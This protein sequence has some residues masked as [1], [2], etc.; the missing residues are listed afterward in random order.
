MLEECQR[1]YGDAFTLRLA[2]LPPIVILSD[3]AAARQVFTG[4]PDK[5][6]SGQANRF[7]E[8]ALG[9]HSLL[10]LDGREHLRERKLMLPPFHGER[11]RAY[12]A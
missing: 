9:R 6:R 3:P 2:G 12:A 11:M 5:L 10:V 8:A 4:D 7:L 1:R